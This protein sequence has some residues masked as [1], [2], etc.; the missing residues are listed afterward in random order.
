M[1]EAARHL[2]WRSGAGL[3]V[4]NMIGV[5]VLTS[6]GYMASDLGPATI[7]IVWL[8]GGVLAISGARSYAA[9]AQI[10]PRSGG[11]YRYVSDLLHPA[12]GYL[13]GWTSVVVGFSAPIAV[14]ALVAGAFAATLS[15]VNPRV[16][17][18]ALIG[19]LSLVHA[20]R[21]DWSRRL[22]NGLVWIELLLLVGFVSGGLAFG[23]N[24]F[25][26]WQPVNRAA[27]FPLS[28]FVRA[29][30]FVA[31]AYSGWN[32][33]SYLADE[34]R[35]PKRDVARA[36]T[37]GTLIVTALYLLVNWVFV[38]NLSAERLSAWA[39]GDTERITLGHLLMAD[40][41]GPRAAQAMS[42]LV[43]LAM[44]A[45]ISSMVIAGPRV[46]STMARDGFLP[47]AFT[48]R[49]GRPPALA[50]LSQSALAIVLVFSHSFSALIQ[51]IGAVLTL[52]S[53]LA[54]IG[55][56]RARKRASFSLVAPITFLLLAG[57]MLLYGF[58]D[59]PSSLI[60]IGGAFALSLVGY[61]MSPSRR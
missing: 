36:L 7:L 6:T 8:L 41:A 18:V 61:R 44:A 46:C 40:L 27:G 26:S 28:A 13:A 56:L 57:A 2:G 10:I 38:A 1:S 15:P 34:F 12:L 3:I 60:W 14:S 48:E 20:A 4:A 32:T 5:G 35:D 53:A 52:N 39:H 54:V 47:S 33:A 30:F 49:A 19:G 42:A 31:Y 43:V 25:P 58:F 16:V 59:A 50:V 9:L 51:N 11:E 45:L 17:A 22:Q 21:L 23:Q 29:L 37:V 55:L 24:H